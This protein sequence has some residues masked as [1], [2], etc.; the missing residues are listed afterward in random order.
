MP[1]KETLMFTHKYM[2]VGGIQTYLYRLI[3]KLKK[4]GHRIIWIYPQGTY[5]DDEFFGE[6]FDGSIEIIK[7][8]FDKPNWIKNCEIN[9]DKDE[10]V[11][12]LAFNLFNF[13]FLEKIKK[14]YSLIQIHDF[15]WVPH[16]KEKEVFIE[17]FAPRSIRPL[18]KQIIRKI[19]INM[20]LNDNIVYVNKSHL[21]ALTQNY[22]YNVNNDF[23]KKLLSGNSRDIPE[24]DINL[25]EI[26][27]E[28]TNFNIITV[29]RLSFPHKS[30]ILGLVR[31]YASL[32]PK[33][34][35]LKLTII[36]YGPDEEKVVEEI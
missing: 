26:R 21:D 3:T 12:A 30:Y 20:E 19:I 9:F 10:V 25:N 27:S 28:R 14:K 36:G 2:G 18:F 1:Q 4:E 33:Y 35:Q 34:N 29:S 15:F 11:V 22:S 17:E 6:F 24:Y 8:D 32:K 5:I 31:A 16:F 23:N 13:I 7:V